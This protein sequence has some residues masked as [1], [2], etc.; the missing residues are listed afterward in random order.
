MV[1]TLSRTRSLRERV[2]TNGR[3]NPTLIN[4][5]RLRSCTLNNCKLCQTEGN[6]SPTLQ[7][8]W[9][10]VCLWYSLVCLDPEGIGKRSR[11]TCSKNKLAWLNAAVGPLDESS[12]V[13]DSASASCACNELSKPNETAPPLKVGLTVRMRQRRHP[14]SFAAPSKAYNTGGRQ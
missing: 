3:S 13:T 2:V 7:S 11:R 12:T 4:P 5:R 9:T 8:I 6:R 1:K 10:T 14:P